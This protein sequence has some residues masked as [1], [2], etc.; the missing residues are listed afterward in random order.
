MHY[1]P[2][3]STWCKCTSSTL[4]SSMGSWSALC[5]FQGNQV[6]RRLLRTCAS[7]G[8]RGRL[9][10]NTLV[11]GVESGEEHVF[12]LRTDPLRFKCQPKCH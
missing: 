3:A 2:C 11:N 8:A 6:P 4:S 5:E 9:R 10:I 7:S 12:A 1:M